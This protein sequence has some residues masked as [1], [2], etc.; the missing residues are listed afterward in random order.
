MKKLNKRDE[1]E[2]D[3]Y[4]KHNPT[5]LKSV[6]DQNHVTKKV[7]GSYNKGVDRKKRDVARKMHGTMKSNYS[8]KNY[9]L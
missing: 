3:S 7:S 9:K 8:G 6:I 5:S 2:I 4:V 1:K